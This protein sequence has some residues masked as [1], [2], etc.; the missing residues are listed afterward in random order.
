MDALFQPFVVNYY[1]RHVADIRTRYG[2]NTNVW[3]D[4]WQMGWMVRN[5][6]SHGGYVH[7]RDSTR[8][9]VRWGG[10]EVSPKDQ[11]TKIL[12]NI[13]NY[14]DLILLMIAMEESRAVPIPYADKIIDPPQPQSTSFTLSSTSPKSPG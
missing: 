14:G 6:V 2:G 10:L 13:I 9:P 12:G 11:G 3:P 1:E 8:Q 7:F 5:A 4:A